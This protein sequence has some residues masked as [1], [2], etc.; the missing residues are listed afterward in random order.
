MSKSMPVH[1]FRAVR[2]VLEPD[3]FA[4]G[5]EDP[6]APPSDLVS[7]ETWRALTVL[8]DDVAIRTSDHNGEALTEAYSL[9]CRWL[10]ATGDH[11]DA[12]F[13]PMLDA[14]SDLENSIFNA[15]HGYYRAAFSALRSALE[16]MAIGACGSFAN[17]RQIYAEW[18]SGAAK[19]SFDAASSRLAAEPMLDRFNGELRRSGQSLFDPKDRTRGFAG[20][21]A[22]QL[23][24]ELCD[25]AHSR[26]GFADGDLWCSNGP[27]Y[28]AEVFR[29]WQRAWLHTLSLC[30][31]LVTLARAGAERKEIAKL[32]TDRGDIVPDELRRA[33]SVAMAG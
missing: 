15:L 9:C 8:P 19:F 17:N 29:N 23:Y 18:R 31:V 28:V 7:P 24:G 26:P 20:G 11:V 1:D 10:A 16:L 4:L 32:F 13:D 2:I 25:Y 27:I 12:L 33:F 3:D 5:S 6:D 30:A 21:H 14:R 22:R